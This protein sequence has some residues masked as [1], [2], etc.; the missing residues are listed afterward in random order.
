MNIDLRILLKL[1]YE[2]N[3]FFVLTLKKIVFIIIKVLC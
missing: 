1:N 2:I 3:L